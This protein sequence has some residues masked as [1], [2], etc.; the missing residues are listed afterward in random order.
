MVKNEDCLFCRIV[1]GEL[2]AVKV[3]E[4]E[5]CIAILDAFPVTRGHTLVIPKEHSDDIFGMSDDDVEDAIKLLRDVAAGLK[6]AYGCPGINL[7]KNIGRPAGQV[8][9]HSH[10]HAIPRYGDDNITIRFGKK[11]DFSEAEKA[12]IASD[13]RNNMP[14][15]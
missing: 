8:V 5:K 12:E 3:A 10:F 6:K 1:A 14:G 2:A 13:I 7:L 4:T 15:R 9:F 11:L